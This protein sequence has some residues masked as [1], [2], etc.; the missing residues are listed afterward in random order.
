MN[1]YPISDLWL[2]HSYK[3]SSTT[4]AAIGG[5]ETVRLQMDG[6]TT[7]IAYELFATSAVPGSVGQIPR[8]PFSTVIKKNGQT[9]M[10]AAVRSEALWGTTPTISGIQTPLP[11][12]LKIPIIIEPSTEFN[13]DLVN[14]FAGANDVTLTFR[15]IRVFDKAAAGKIGR[16]R[17]DGKLTRYP[18]EPYIYVLNQVLG[19]SARQQANVQILERG[20]FVVQAITGFSNGRYQIRFT[21]SGKAQSNWDDSLTDDTAVVGSAQWPN[22]IHPRTIRPGATLTADLVDTSVAGNTIQIALLG[23]HRQ[24]LA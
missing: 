14:L 11:M 1:R 24:A 23:Y 9:Y 16:V 3:C 4:L 13:I 17:G 6:Q 18:T 12:K 2:T 20:D 22:W 21:D 19:A 7:F 10:N 8:G 15:G 5:Q